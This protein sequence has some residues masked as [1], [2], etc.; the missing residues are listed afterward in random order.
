MKVWEV[1]ISFTIARRLDAW[2]VGVGHTTPLC[3]HMLPPIDDNPYASPHATD[4]E[5]VHP[6]PDIYGVLL[7]RS[8]VYRRIELH[9]RSNAV[10]EYNGRGLGYETVRVNGDIVARVSGNAVG[11]TTPIDFEIPSRE[12]SFSA[13]LEIKTSF[14]LFLG[15]F[16]LLI[17]GAVVYLEGN[18]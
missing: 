18:W 2:C 12:R 4:C 7:G 15:A 10:I 3:A 11:F 5:L 9:G 14:L 6:H 1:T 8:W 13:R 16:R 17:D